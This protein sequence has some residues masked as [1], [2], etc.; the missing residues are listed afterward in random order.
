VAVPVAAAAAGGGVAWSNQAPVHLRAGALTPIEITATGLTATFVA[1][2]ETLGI[3]WQPVPA[4]S[5]YSDVL[6]GYLGT[7][8]LR[9]LK[10]AAL[11]SDLSLTAAEMAFLATSSGLTV[12]GKG[13]LAVL[14]VDSPAA[15]ANYGD[16]AAVLDGLTAFATLKATY[17]PA[18]TRTPQLLTT[19]R[20]MLVGATGADNKLLALTGWDAGS[21]PP[22]LARLFGVDT[23]GTADQSVAAF[24]S[25]PGIFANLL[26]LQAAFAIVKTCG[27]SAPTLIEAATNDPSAAAASTVLPDFQSAVRSRY[28]EADWLTVVQPI[29]DQLREM[30]RD[31]LVAYVLVQS[32]STILNTL[33]IAASSTRL[34]T[35]DDLFNY[36]LADVEMQPCMLTSRVRLALSAVQLFIERCLRNLEPTV[37][38]S[39]IDPSEWEWRKRYRVWQANREVFLW[40]EN[41][42]DPSLRDD[43]S[44][45]FKSVMSQLLQSDITNDSAAEGY[46]DYLSNLEL[47]AKLDPCGFYVDPVAN[48]AHV[49]ART[50]GAHRKYYYRRFENGAWDAWDEVKLNIEDVPV[51]PYVWKGRLMLFWLQIHHQPANSANSIGNNLP[52]T[53]SGASNLA[54]TSVGQLS[55]AVAGSAPGLAAEQV[56]AVLYFSEYY[57]GAWQPTKSSDPSNPLVLGMFQQGDFDRTA[58]F[59]RPWAPADGNDESLFLQ[60]AGYAG[61]WFDGGF[62][63]PPVW[64]YTEDVKSGFVLHNTHSA[65][66]TWDQVP[67]TMVAM[68][69][70]V[71]VL[72]S[73]QANPFGPRAL[74]VEYQTETSEG[75]IPYPVDVD[76]AI[77]V[78]GGL[79]Q[80]IVD[81]QPTV[82]QPWDMPFFFGDSRSVFYVT[83]GEWVIPIIDWGGF[84][85]W[86]MAAPADGANLAVQIPP[87]VVVDGPVQPDPPPEVSATVVDPAVAAAAVSAGAARAVIAGGGAVAF[88]GRNVSVTGSTGA[89][90]EKAA[91]AAPAQGGAA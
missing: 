88:D 48:I 44:P 16:L 58:W 6:V 8:T 35:A 89:P 36:F 76:S 18:A 47:V 27:L 63:W 64:G 84:G 43:K 9:F 46:L 78:M 5:L 54:E 80:K 66:V 73:A 79:P 71:R 37:D 70:N 2:W 15:P 67:G 91:A 49:V 82:S 50:P 10:A 81:A 38:A 40:P 53:P 77:I 34:P 26:R 20:D 65:P 52:Q 87:L 32:G 7:T 14:D 72:K 17:S 74:T 39:G 59:L 69:P 4:Q 55:T 85:V 61:A 68:S 13:W 90:A 42:L 3:G 83:C 31:A 75:Q 57:N 62:L 41:W 19:L 1:S 23:S 21:L 51:V 22:L 56:G 25:L 12:E 33:G 28:A 45:I 24:A 30:Q 86:H 29:N 60:V 11:A